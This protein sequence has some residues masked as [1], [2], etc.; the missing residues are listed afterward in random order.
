MTPNEQRVA[1]AEACGYEIRY[2]KRHCIE[3][4]GP[5]PENRN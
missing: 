3:A 4:W 1:I 5:I 2:I